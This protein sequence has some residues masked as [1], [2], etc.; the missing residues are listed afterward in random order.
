MVP[1]FKTKNTQIT[2]RNILPVKHNGGDIM[3]WAFCSAF[4]PWYD[5]G[6]LLNSEGKWISNRL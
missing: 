1:K 4:E 3:V 6:F 2:T 5:K